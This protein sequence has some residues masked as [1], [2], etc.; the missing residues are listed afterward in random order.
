MTKPSKTATTAMSVRL[1]AA[2]SD[3][4]ATPSQT[5]EHLTKVSA[6]G[7]TVIRNNFVQERRGARWVGSSL[8]R[9]VRARQPRALLGYLLLLM[10]WSALDRRSKPLEAVVW[11]RALSPDPPS[12]PWA[13]SAMSRVWTTLEGAPHQLVTRERKARLVKLSPRQE[14]GRSPYTRPRPDESTRAS[15]KFFILPDAFWLDGWYQ[16]LSMPGVAVLLILLAG[17][18]GR[19]EA[20]LSPEHA[21]EWY[22]IAEKTMRNGLE[23][24]RREGLVTERREWVTEPLSPIGKTQRLYCC[25]T[26]VFSREERRQLQTAA[27]S[28][29]RKRATK[30]TNLAKRRTTRAS[31]DAAS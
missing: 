30:K 29:T 2:T 24:L 22:G 17:T 7:Y 28:A 8:G 19:D 18:T 14:N 25:L 23:E 13:A 11:A 27:A 26:G 5:R 12:P 1:T 10:S 31:S 15:E 20:R 6:R 21:H 9:L 3:P 4:T 16:R